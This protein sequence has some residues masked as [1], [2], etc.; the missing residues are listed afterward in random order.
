[1]FGNEFSIHNCKDKIIVDPTFIFFLHFFFLSSFSFYQ[2]STFINFS[3]DSPPSASFIP[4]FYH[5]KHNA[6]VQADCDHHVI[7]CRIP[8][9]LILPICLNILNSY[10]YNHHP[11][12]TLIHISIPIFFSFFFLPLLRGKSVHIQEVR[13]CVSKPPVIDSVVQDI[14]VLL[15]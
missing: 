8:L 15:P 10:V 6:K 9:V 2:T 12:K 13:N 1:M 11:I 5:T 4:L 7:E 14:K 3:S